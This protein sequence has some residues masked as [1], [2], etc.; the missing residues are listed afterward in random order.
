MRQKKRSEKPSRLFWA[1]FRRAAT[2][3]LCAQKVG[4]DAP[5]DGRGWTASAKDALLSIASFPP[6]PRFTEAQ[7]R[8]VPSSISG[9]G[10]SRHSKPLFFATAPLAV[11]ETCRPTGHA[12]CHQAPALGALSRAAGN[13]CLSR[14]QWQWRRGARQSWLA[15][16][17]SIERR[18]EGPV[19]AFLWISKTVSFGAYKRNGFWSVP[20]K[21]AVLG[22]GQ[23]LRP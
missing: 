22:P 13:L 7:D 14:H 2:Y 19:S 20:L 11:V 16:R 15:Q 21:D 8:K 1:K 17:R 5:G 9:V 3:F 4:K 6:V 12:Y 10:V 18:T 23:G